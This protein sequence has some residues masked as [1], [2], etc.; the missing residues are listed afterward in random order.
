MNKRVATVAAL[1]AVLIAGGASAA[2]AA[3]AAPVSSITVKASSTK[4]KLGD[5]VTFTGKT[6]GLKDGST[7]TLQV[8]HGTKW[9]SLPATAKVNKAAYKLSSKLQEKGREVLRVK[10][11]KAVSKSIAVVVG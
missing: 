9:V 2:V 11:G 4:V 1:S 6:A 5:P 3:P 10:D 8:K 7:V